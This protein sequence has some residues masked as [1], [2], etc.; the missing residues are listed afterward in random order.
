MMHQTKK[1]I[2]TIQAAKGEIM[3]DGDKEII[4]HFI[5]T[6]EKT[7]ELLKRV[8]DEWLNR[9]PDGEKHTLKHLFLHAGCGEAWWMSVVLKDGGKPHYD[10][11]DSKNEITAAI[12]DAKQRVI[13]F[14]TTEDGQRINRTFSWTDEQGTKY[15]WTGRDRLFY[16]SDHEIHHRGKIVLA[17]RQWGMTEFP[18]IPY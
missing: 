11:G 2:Q 3:N 16:Y 10:C 1:A 17:L 13:S 6:R 5:K 9:T 12:E 4:E 8:P 18:C 15:E 14:F 7:K